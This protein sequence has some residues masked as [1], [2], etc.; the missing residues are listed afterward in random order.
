[1]HEKLPVPPDHDGAVWPHAMP[2]PI[3]PR[4]R[5]TELEL[6]LVLR[7]TG[8]YL[9]EDR[10]Y[11][12]NPGA[13]IWLFPGQQHILLDMSP[14][15]RM[16]ILVFRPRLLRRLC[17]DPARRVLQSAAPTGD[18]CR[19]LSDS[20]R[21]K[22]DRQFDDLQSRRSDALHHNTAIATALLDSWAAFQTADQ[23]VLS[24]DL[25]PAVRKAA[26]LLQTAPDSASL[27]ALA[28]QAG[29][30]RTRLSELFKRQT[31]VTLVDFRNRARLGRFHALLDATPPAQRKLLPLALA[32][33]FGSYQQF[34]RVFKHHSGRGPAAHLR[35]D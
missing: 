7:G 20:V 28:R 22:L 31:G 3:H 34:Y 15:Y 17:A 30:S 12:L 19:Q 29:L 26:R 33:G 2:A 9:V 32:A 35:A 6:N 1:M 8:R 10:G 14:D 13:L 11:E 18:F 27:A 23:P 5:H 21:R 4:H 24:A 16:W 25:H